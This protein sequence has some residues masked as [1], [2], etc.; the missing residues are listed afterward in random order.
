MRGT[1]I[2][3]SIIVVSILLTGCNIKIGDGILTVSEDGVQY[4]TREQSNANN[5]LTNINNEDATDDGKTTEYATGNNDSSDADTDQSREAIENPSTSTNVLSDS[6]MEDLKKVAE[7]L[8]KIGEEL[9][10]GISLD[11]SQSQRKRNQNQCEEGINENY[12]EVREKLNHEFYFPPCTHLVSVKEQG[13]LV[14]FVLEQRLNKWSTDSKGKFIMEM[15]AIEDAYVEFGGNDVY[16][17][18]VHYADLYGEVKFYLH[19]TNRGDTQVH[20]IYWGDHIEI[21]VTYRH[22]P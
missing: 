22:P 15:E 2:L 17:N 8:A 5:D 1:I 19:G 9:W 11:E 13:S 3:F 16:E 6:E 18:Y 12:S 7:E 20:F 21:R 14:Q 10:S 4:V